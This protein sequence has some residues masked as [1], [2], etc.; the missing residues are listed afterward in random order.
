[1]NGKSKEYKILVERENKMLV[2]TALLTIFCVSAGIGAE[3]QEVYPHL[4]VNFWIP[5]ITLILLIVLGFLLD[6]FVDFKEVMTVTFQVEQVVLKRKNKERII[7]YSSI[8]KVVKIMVFNRTYQDKGKYRV[9]IKCKSRNYA[10]Y[11]GEDYDLKLDFEQ[12]EVSKVYYELKNRGI[13]CC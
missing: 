1:M 5:F 11:S 7:P 6:K 8:K 10:M 4:D 12:T 13:I 3:L 2:L 9:V